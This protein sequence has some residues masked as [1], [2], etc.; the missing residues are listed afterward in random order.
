MTATTWFEQYA[1][2]RPADFAI[3][4][5]G[6]PYMLRW[7]L[8]P[9][10]DL[11]G[12]Y[13][14]RFLRDDDPRAYHD[15]PWD[16]VSIVLSGTLLERRPRLGDRFLMP[17]D[18]VKRTAEMQHRLE[19]IEPGYT[20]FQFGPKVREWGFQCAEGWRHWTR[21]V[22]GLGRGQVGI[23]CGEYGDPETEAT[24]LSIESD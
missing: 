4:P 10:S 11:G 22:D 19:V 9:R 3:G 8:T 13:L 7:Y 1:E 23:G 17:G 18:I 5:V 21:Y 2:S 6:E 15:H 12:I 14:H 16:S 24:P 20:L